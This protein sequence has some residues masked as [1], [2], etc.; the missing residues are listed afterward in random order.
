MS[1]KPEV[2]AGNSGEWASTALRFET[3][4]E[5][6]DNVAAMAWRWTAV[7][8]TRVAESDDPVNARWES[9]KT[10]HLDSPVLKV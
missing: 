2:I 4:A 6:L 3:K 5:A 1:W 9:G 7:R 8:E 10:V